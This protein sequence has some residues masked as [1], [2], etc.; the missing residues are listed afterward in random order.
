MIVRKKDSTTSAVA[1][2]STKPAAK[3]APTGSLATVMKLTVASTLLTAKSNDSATGVSRQHLCNSA[4][5]QWQGKLQQKDKASQHP[6]FLHQG[7]H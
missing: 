4:R 5:D 2:V 7:L 6:I 1:A 3:T